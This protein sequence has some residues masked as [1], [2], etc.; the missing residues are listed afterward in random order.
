MIEFDLVNLVAL[1]IGLG[2]FGFVEP[3][4][5]GSTLVFIKYLEGKSAAE[6]L[7]QVA[8][9]TVTRALFIGLL[10]VLAVLIGAAFIGFQ[11]AA[12]IVL[13]AI[14]VAIGVLYLTGRAEALMLSIGPSLSRISGSRGSVS[15]GLLFGLNIPACAAP[16]IFALLGTA[17]AAGVAGNTLAAGFISL[18]LFGFALSLPL[19]LAVLFEPARRLLDRLAALS[20]RLP[21]W[22]G[23]LLIGLG[24][25]SIGFGLFAEV[26]PRRP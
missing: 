17:A 8:L 15:L 26:T 7:A 1:P 2:L 24:L 23:V 4:S 12:W 13:G 22:T 5:I 25:W 6:K 3:C 21:L 14:Y 18:G 16:L 10:G 11:K 9:F 20:K 19:V